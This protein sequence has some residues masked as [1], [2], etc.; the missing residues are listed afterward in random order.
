MEGVAEADLQFCEQGVDVAN[1][2]AGF[3]AS[4]GHITR[5]MVKMK[6]GTQH[7]TRNHSGRASIDLSGTMEGTRICRDPPW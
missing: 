4:I 3:D 7:E 1:N 5:N 6:C 2:L